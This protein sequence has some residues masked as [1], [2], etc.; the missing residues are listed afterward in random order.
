MIRT[1]KLGLIIVGPIIVMRIPGMRIIVMR[2]PR[3][4]K[5][6]DY[7]IAVHPLLRELTIL[8]TNTIT[9]PSLGRVYTAL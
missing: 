5:G 9:F 3:M 7:H 4:R 2:I 6:G 1:E 8:N